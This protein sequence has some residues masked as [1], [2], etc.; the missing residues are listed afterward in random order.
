M[1][2]IF[3]DYDQI[4]TS[5]VVHDLS[6]ISGW[7]LRNEG[8]LDYHIHDK[9]PVDKGELF[10]GFYLPPFQRPECWDTER[11]IRFIESIFCG[12]PTGTLMYVSNGEAPEVDGWL[13]DGQQRLTA[14]RDFVTGKFAIFGDRLAYPDLKETELSFPGADARRAWNIW[15]GANLDFLRIQESDPA[16]LVRIYERL[17][18]GGVP[19]TE[20]QRPSFPKA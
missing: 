12:I 9:E 6:Q 17:N 13:I 5:N 1:T 20:A 2:N 10:C 15:R 8:A 18:F 7:I 16:I 4:W 19:H 3:I 14:V 11:K